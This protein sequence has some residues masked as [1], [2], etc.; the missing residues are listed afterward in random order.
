MTASSFFFISNQIATETFYEIEVEQ[1][2]TIED[3]SNDSDIIIPSLDCLPCNFD[4][5]Y[6]C[7]VTQKFD[8]SQ[9]CELTLKQI[10]H[11]DGMDEEKGDCSLSE[12]A[13]IPINEY[14]SASSCTTGSREV[15]DTHQPSDNPLAPRCF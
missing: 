4:C 6:E 9:E 14:D 7:F 5:Y 2:I 13:V 11:L 12:K 3:N 10:P 8:Y 1:Q 15:S